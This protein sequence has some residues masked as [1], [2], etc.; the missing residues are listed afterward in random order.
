MYSLTSFSG[1]FSALAGFFYIGI[2]FIYLTSKDKKRR[3][4]F[5]YVCF[6]YILVTM[7]TGNRGHQVINIIGILLVVF[8]DSGKRIPFRKLVVY[9]LAGFIGLSFIDMIFSVRHEGI[10]FLVQNFSTVLSDTME[11]NILLET[12]NNFGATVFTVYL[13]LE[14]VGN[15]IHPFFG[16]A[17]VKS[18]ASI[19]PDI[20]GVFSQINKGAIFSR[21]LNTAHQIGGSLVGEFYYNFRSL[22]WLA[23]I[24]FGLL[25]GSL[26]G[27]IYKAIREKNYSVLC[28]TL[29]LAVYS[30]WWVRDTIGGVTRSVVWLY[31]IY[32]LISRSPAIRE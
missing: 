10:N 7:L 32:L 14:R 16:E 26:S 2:S 30:M 23:G 31:I 3:K 28:S 5:L 25:Y 13:V 27:N 29:P 8:I 15:T 21:N 20:G 18:I 19:V 1:V 4:L 12:L 17:F 9:L 22:Y 11:K 6:A 24:V